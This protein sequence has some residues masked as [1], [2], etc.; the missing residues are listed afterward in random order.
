VQKAA[1]VETQQPASA[2]SSAAS[3]EAHSQLIKIP[4]L[5]DV[6]RESFIYSGTQGCGATVLG[7]GRD[8][9]T[10]E[11]YNPTSLNVNNLG[12]AA[13]LHFASH[14]LLQLGPG[15]T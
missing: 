9:V 1:L 13:A 3:Q 10:K 8:I 4:V 5:R 2:A 7:K 15:Q 11:T 12:K 14:S 6:F